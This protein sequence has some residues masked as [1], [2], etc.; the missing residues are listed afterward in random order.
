MKVRISHNYIPGCVCL[1]VCMCVSVGDHKSY[2]GVGS[3]SL[4]AELCSYGQHLSNEESPFPR[5]NRVYIRVARI[6]LSTSIFPFYSVPHSHARSRDGTCREGVTVSPRF[7]L[8]SL[9]TLVYT[10]I[11]DRRK[12]ADFA[13]P[14]IIICFSHLF[15]LASIS[16]RHLLYTPT[17][18]RRRFLAIRNAKIFLRW[19]CD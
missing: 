12:T 14:R 8:P 18:P 17:F 7:L 6:K 2:Y 11:Y 10:A 5:F 19:D 9:A 16:L 1:S 15:S 4:P 3:S 13:D